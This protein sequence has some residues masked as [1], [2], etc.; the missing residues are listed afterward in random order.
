MSATLDDAQLFD[1]LS[2]IF[3]SLKVVHIPSRSHPVTVHYSRET[4]LD[5]IE[6]AENKVCKIH[7]KLPP[8]A[9][10]VF[11]SGREEVRTLC[12][13]LT[14]ELCSEKSDKVVILPLFS[15]LPSNQQARVFEVYPK[16]VRKI[17]VATNIAE[18]SITIPDV[19][20]I[21]DS[22]KC[23]EVSWMTGLVSSSSLPVE[24]VSKASA[25]QRAGRAG[26]TGPGHCYRLYSSPIFHGFKPSRT[27][28]ILRV[29]IDSLV[30]RLKAM[31]VSDIARFPFI[32]KP[33]LS[34]C[35]AA[36]ERLRLLG[37]LRRV[38]RGNETKGFQSITETGL[39]MAKLPVS[40]RIARSLLATT[41]DFELTRYACRLAG[42]LSV[43]TVWNCATE[44]GK[45]ASFESKFS[46]MGTDLRAVCGMEK[47]NHVTLD[48]KDGGKHYCE[49]YGLNY[50]AVAEALSI[51]SQVE[52]IFLS[53]NVNRD[54]LPCLTQKM[55]EQLLR[56]FC[57]GFGDQI[58]RKV[59]SVEAGKCEKTRKFR[60]RLYAL[61]DGTSCVLDR[62][63]SL[64]SVQWGC[65]FVCY[66]RLERKSMSVS[67][68]RNGVG[69][70]VDDSAEKEEFLVMKGVTLVDKAWVA[71]LCPS[72]C[73][74]KA[75]SPSNPS[76][77]YD[78]QALSVSILCKQMYRS[79]TVGEVNVAAAK[80]FA[81]SSDED[82][83]EKIRDKCLEVFARAILAGRVEIAGGKIELSTSLPKY[84]AVHRLAAKLRQHGA[85]FSSQLLAENLGRQGNFLHAA[86]TR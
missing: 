84:V 13:R 2:A 27:P 40:P 34:A 21:V 63:S 25:E 22:G 14:A 35:A 61:P 62:S 1:G 52:K 73:H 9:V 42:I 54:V 20:Y 4:P 48:I 33:S 72:I 19:A 82:Y 24:W 53:G 3:G 66:V 78:D 26:R 58:A 68:I 46:D 80:Y 70:G 76:V 30:L 8:G 16:Q 12:A 55:E 5:Y 23:K 59:Q 39:K 32:T 47:E 50:K 65:D 79:W 81:G 15:T 11:L 64:K 85:P 86:L 37:A 28:E 51:S 6:A 18:T 44:K 36:E 56:R 10:L 83:E 57:R 38:E 75:V 67:R 69:N 31:G 49:R 60:G 29:P 45:G 77:C 71:G 7:R 43:G 17:I 74:V 41:G